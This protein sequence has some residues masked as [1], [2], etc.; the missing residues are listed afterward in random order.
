MGKKDIFVKMVEIWMEIT[1][2]KLLH[3][4][5]IGLSLLSSTSKYMRVLQITVLA[6]CF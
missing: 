2:Y 4:I 5:D 3:H 6:Y 1:D